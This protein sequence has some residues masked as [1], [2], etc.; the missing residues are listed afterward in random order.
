MK[1][2][3]KQKIQKQQES[4]QSVGKNRINKIF[5][6]ILKRATLFSNETKMT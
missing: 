1:V 6:G 5:K 4:L 2:I 3:L